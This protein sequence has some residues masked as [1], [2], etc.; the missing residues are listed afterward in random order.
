MGA[1]KGGSNI[2]FDAPVGDKASV[3]SLRPKGSD[4]GSENGLTHRT[5]QRPRLRFIEFDLS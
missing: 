5:L 3:L 1:R 4:L 2:S